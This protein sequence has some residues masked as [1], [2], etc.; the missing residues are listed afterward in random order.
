MQ[1][2]VYKFK[3][4]SDLHADINGNFFYKDKPATKVYNNGS[5]SLLIGKSKISIKKLRANAYKEYIQKV[6]LPF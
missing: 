5:V 3:G 1:E 2:I 4:F 6:I